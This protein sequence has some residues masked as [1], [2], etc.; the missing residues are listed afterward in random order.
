[1]TNKKLKSFL[2]L[3]FIFLSFTVFSGSS[4]NEEII[5][6]ITVD[7]NLQNDG[8]AVITEVCDVIVLEGSEWYV[9]H[10]RMSD[11]MKIQDFVV[12]AED[13]VPFENVDWNVDASF[14]QKT[15]KSGIVKTDSGY[16][17]CWGLGN[18]GHRVFKITYT[19]TN[20]VR[21]YSDYDGFDFEFVTDNLGLPVNEVEILIGSNSANLQDKIQ[22]W[23]NGFDAPDVQI[24]DRA[25][26][27]AKYNILESDFFEIIM[28]IEKGVLNP[29]AKESSSFEDVKEYAGLIK[30][31]D[32]SNN[33]IISN[34]NPN[35]EISNNETQDNRNSNNSSNAKNSN[36]TSIADVIFKIIGSMFIIIPVMFIFCY[37]YLFSAAEAVTDVADIT[38]VILVTADSDTDII[39][40][41]IQTDHMY[42]EEVPVVHR[43][44]EVRHHQEVLRLHREVL[45]LHQA[46]L[47]QE[48][49]AAL[50]EAAAEVV[51]A[52][53]VAEAD[54]N[55]SVSSIST[56][57]VL[58]K[59]K[60]IC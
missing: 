12:R 36:K 22:A 42:T 41:E 60:L 39:T 14:E 48:V 30:S 19:L 27:N 11:D 50:Q 31:S 47:P 53:E 56:E 21:S 7:V 10:E 28:Q 4:P 33:E 55:I 23:G 58:R 20:L 24:R 37:L 34:E 44:Q 5:N 3:E 17:L 1:M 38:I 13:G 16:E 9:V 40:A 45:H 51:R 26:F 25:L 15:N 46:V 29:V 8:S 32:N 18:Y 57:Y 54:D 2:S 52:E 49:R 59:R 43:L 35:N 6:K